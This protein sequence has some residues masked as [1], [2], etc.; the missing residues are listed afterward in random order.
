MSY[1]YL[2]DIDRNRSRLGCFVLIGLAVVVV[3]ATAWFFWPESER[4][5]IETPEELTAALEERIRT[6]PQEAPPP[7]AAQQTAR[8]APATAQ[9]PRAAARPDRGTEWLAEA[10]AARDEDNLLRAR[11]LGWK[12][13]EEST[14]PAVRRA[15]ED[16]LGAVNIEL[17]M[18]PRS[19]PEKIDYVVQP[20]DTLGGIARRYVPAP[21]HTGF[22]D[23]L[24]H[25][26]RLRGPRDRPILRVGDRIRILDAD[27]SIEVS[28]SRNE[29]VLFMNG[30][31][32][33]RYPV[34][35]GE[36]GSTPVGEFIVDPRGILR[37]PAWPCRET[38]RLIPYGHTDNPLGTRWI[39]FDIAGYGIHGTTQPETIGYQLSDGCVRMYNEDVE[40][41]FMLVRGNMP[42]TIV[43]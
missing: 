16:L 33:K 37:E 8:A 19:M 18:T 32:F 35:T 29:L 28:K 10:N 17:V 20:G 5:P 1:T 38:G 15:A 34:G 39:G 2:E 25:S 31:F 43:E 13:L 14:D 9:R 27:F 7:P 42:V 24:H 36:F 22:L 23:L 30:K 6:S 3:F 40:E 4:Q 41:L 21:G 26:N 11:E 12:I